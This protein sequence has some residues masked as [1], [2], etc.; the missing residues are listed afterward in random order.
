MIHAIWLFLLGNWE[1]DTF[2]LCKEKK[3]SNFAQ[4]IWRQ[5]TKF[6]RPDVSIANFSDWVSMSVE[7]PKI[8]LHKLIPQKVVY[9]S[10]FLSS[11]QFYS[12]LFLKLRTLPSTRRSHARTFF[13][14]SSEK[15]SHFA[16]LP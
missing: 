13:M 8:H 4:T 14:S 5:R 10:F 3:F 16:I 1:L 7:R 11:Y 9:S 6:S 2:F 15:P 12:I